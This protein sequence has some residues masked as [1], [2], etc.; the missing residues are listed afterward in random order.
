MYLN[1]FCSKEMQIVIYKLTLLSP[2]PVVLKTLSVIP[3]DRT[4]QPT[5]PKKFTVQEELFQRE[6][7]VVF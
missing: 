4:S 3:R 5:I 6:C 7:K 2:K 1:R